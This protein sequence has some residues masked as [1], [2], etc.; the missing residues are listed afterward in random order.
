MPA[1]DNILPQGK[2]TGLSFII[3]G[4]YLCLQFTKPEPKKDF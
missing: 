4:S 3:T 1:D 2:E